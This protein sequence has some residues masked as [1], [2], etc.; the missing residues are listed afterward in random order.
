MPC[1]LPA[2]LQSA[3]PCLVPL[4]RARSL[5]LERGDLL[6]RARSLRREHSELLRRARSLRLERSEAVMEG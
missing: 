6:R 3:P 5:R 1:R 2:A 4:R